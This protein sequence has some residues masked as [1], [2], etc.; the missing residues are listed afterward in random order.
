MWRVPLLMA[1]L[2]LP[3]WAGADC[4]ASQFWCNAEDVEL[5]SEN[6][7]E[8]V[9]SPSEP[10][11]F[12]EQDGQHAVLRTGKIGNG[13]CG[14]DVN[15]FDEFV[16]RDLPDGTLVNGT[17]VLSLTGWSY[18]SADPDSAE[19]GF[20]TIYAA[21]TS[22]GRGESFMFEAPKGSGR[23]AI[24]PPTQLAIPISV[25]AGEAFVLWFQNGVST[26]GT[27]EAVVSGT[28]RF[29]NLPTGASVHGCKG[30]RQSTAVPAR[31]L[32]WGSLK[33]VYR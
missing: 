13:A 28:L 32:S 2:L 9:C 10:H 19:H 31:S 27:G 22:G 30:F 3:S 23:V 20:A 25:V 8:R 1:L 16:I 7:W 11:C 4:P 12:A 17:A 21:L 33:S 15:F 26:H 24:P 6:D 18:R 14:T 5:I 29:E